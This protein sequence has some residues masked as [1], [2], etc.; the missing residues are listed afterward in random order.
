MQSPN[1]PF[2]ILAM[3]PFLPPDPSSNHTSPVRV[4]PLELDRAIEAL[5]PTFSIPLPR[6]WYPPPENLEIRIR[7]LKDFHPDRLVQTIPVLKNICAAKDYVQESG[8]K[9]LSA[10][11]INTGLR[12]WPDLPP[13]KIEPAPQKPS[14]TRSSIDSI[15]DMV[16]LPDSS[17]GNA[18]ESKDGIAQLEDLLQN[19]LK[20]VLLNDTF[21]MLESSWR[22]LRLL[23]QHIDHNAD[24]AVEIVPVNA[25]TLDQTIEWLT[26][27]LI[28]DM[29][30]LLLVDL[31]FSSSPRS[32]SLLEQIAKLAE[33]LL[34]PAIVGLAPSFFHLDKWHDLKKLAYLPHYLQEPPYSKWQRLKQSSAARWLV[35]TCNGFLSRYPY[36]SE[37]PPRRVRFQEGKYLWANPVWALASLVV[38]SFTKTGWPTRFA[39][40]RQFRIKDLPLNASDPNTM[41]PTEIH[42]DRDRMDQMIRSGIIPLTSMAN[43]DFVFAPAETTVGGDA[44]SYQLFVSRMTQLILWCRD[45]L[46]RDLTG[47][48]LALELRQNFALFWE[49][50][51]AM[52]LPRLDISVAEPAADGRIPVRIELHPSR[53]ILSSEK[54][55]ELDFYW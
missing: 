53:E 22:G 8:K 46:P 44:L 39:D 18:T 27:Q 21:S 1:I 50:Y 24:L 26:P 11:D 16:D 20:S 34:I 43:K 47:T 9:G 15:L 32:L 13:I 31:S 54:T 2:K 28:E 45:N 40:W 3:A 29:P 14:Q 49:T 30:S 33:I 23:L 51:G 4:E 10:D 7:K 52:A 41:I 19:I 37:N 35:S 12:R 55:V 38:Q 6:A 42:L 48:A 36:G 5:Q 17:G 25:D